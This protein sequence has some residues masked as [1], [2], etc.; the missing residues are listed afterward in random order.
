M[1]KSIEMKKQLDAVK[2][3]ISTLQA[4]GKIPEAHAKLTALNEMKQAIQVQE[5]LETEEDDGFG[6]GS[7]TPV[8]Q[9][10]EADEKKV[11]NRV[12]NKQVLG[13]PLAEDEM[14]F[15]VNTVGTP[16]Q[17]GATPAKGGYLLAEEQFN[18]VL[19]FRRDLTALKN[20]C[21]VVPVTRRSGSIPTTTDDSTTLT[22]FD[23]L[24]TITKADIDFSSVPFSVVDYGE[25]I[26]ASKS[27]LEDIDVDLVS[28]IGRRFA[29]KGVR[30]ENSKILTLLAAL[31]PAA[32]TDYKGIKKALNKTIDPALVEGSIILTNQSGF[33]YL[34]NIELDNGSPLLQ[35]V[36]TDPTKKRFGGH[37]VVV[38]S[39][40]QLPEV[41]GTPNKIPFYVGNLYEYAKFF[42]RKQVTIDSSVDAG[43]TSNALFLRAIER[44]DVKTA[45]S[46]AMAYLQLPV[47]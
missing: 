21:E 8:N 46:A 9:I 17:V 10:P 6:G 37:E 39:N 14:R 47:A 19:E 11:R 20:Y 24:D 3:E 38:L 25:I 32:I 33:D 45:D 41:S 13:V 29:R 7:P 16:G 36:L 34:D 30:T 22:N 2:N 42:D 4:S 35:P 31:T 1:R 15:A 27:L 18:R 5:A 23:E 26:P 40:A 12:F 43:F 44:F 28:L